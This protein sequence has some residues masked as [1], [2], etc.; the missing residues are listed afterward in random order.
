MGQVGV[1][2]AVERTI[3]LLSFLMDKA[4]TDLSPRDWQDAVELL[5]KHLAANR[6]VVELRMFAQVFE[7]P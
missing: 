6:N 5:R 4:P 1:G 7:H 2:E 3:G